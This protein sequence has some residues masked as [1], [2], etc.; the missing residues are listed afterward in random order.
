MKCQ[1]I[2]IYATDRRRDRE[3]DKQTDRQTGRHADRHAVELRGWVSNGGGNFKFITNPIN[4]SW[5]KII[6]LLQRWQ[7]KKQI[8]VDG[9]VPLASVSS[10]DP[11]SPIPFLLPL[12]AILRQP[13]L[14]E[15][16]LG[17]IVNA[18]KQKLTLFATKRKQTNVNMQV[19]AAQLQYTL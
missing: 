11:L 4:P 7:S 2:A 18:A 13:P 9:A 5:I 10:A 15:P 1:K 17:K 16:F 14:P 6:Y 8:H 3:T 19:L 12:L